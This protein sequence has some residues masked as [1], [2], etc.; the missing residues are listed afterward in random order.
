MV[1]SLKS[2]LTCALSL[3]DARPI[4]KA[5]GKDEPSLGLAGNQLALSNADAAVLSVD[6]SKLPPFPKAG[7][8]FTS[9]I[10]AVPGTRHRSH[11]SSFW[12]CSA[13]ASPIFRLQPAC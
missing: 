10:A 4:L 9:R 8:T 1:I 13:H 12:D 11:A 3:S 2:L 5:V 7:I 6:I